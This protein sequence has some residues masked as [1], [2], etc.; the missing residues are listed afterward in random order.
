MKKCRLCGSQIDKI[1][2]DG[3]IRSAGV[4]SETV[5]G[6]EI[7]ECINCKLVQIYPVPDNL[8]EFYET[9]EYRSKFDLSFD[10]DS[11]HKKYDHEQN[12]R[13][14]RIGVQNLRNKIVL[15]LGASAGVFL[16]AVQSLASETIAIEPANIYRDYLTSKKHRYYPYP[17]DA[18]SNSIQA[19]IVTCF[20]VIE[21]LSDPKLLV[22]NAFKLLK[23]GGIFILSMP[24]LNDFLR[25]IQKHDFEEFFFMKVHLNYFSETVIHELFKDLNFKALKIDYLHKYGIENM[26]RW[27]KY[28]EPGPIN[29]FEG[30]FDR[31]SN[32]NFKQNIERQGISSHLFITIV[33][34]IKL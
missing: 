23:P 7:L 4:G 31:F 2:Y 12:E 30:I 33:K 19:D 32:A 14:N 34:D 26:L 1:I 28:G 16:D 17:E 18:I 9:E 22:Q 6:Y 11:I 24:N 27:M 10:P 21:H 29:E 3:P 13:I 5:K 15:D 8:E 25:K 20:D